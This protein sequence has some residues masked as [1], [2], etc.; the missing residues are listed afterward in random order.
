[1]SIQQIINGNLTQ[2]ICEAHITL[3]I[4]ESGSISGLESEQIREGLRNFIDSQVYTENKI[5]LIGMSDSDNNLRNDHLLNN[6]ITSSSITSYKSWINSFRLRTGN[7]IS[8]NSDYWAS[9]LQVVNSMQLPPDIVV[10]ITDGLQVQTPSVLKTLMATLNSSS[11]IFVYGINPGGDYHNGNDLKE[12]LTYYLGRNPILS[13]V[14]TDILTADYRNVLDFSALKEALGSLSQTLIDSNIG[15]GTLQLVKEDIDVGRISLDCINS[16]LNVGTITIKNNKGV[17]YLME[18][19]TEVAKINGLVFSS[20]ANV[21]LLPEG[22]EAK[23]PVQVNGTPLSIGYFTKNIEIEGIDNQYGLLVDFCVQDISL[24]KNSEVETVVGSQYQEYIGKLCQYK[25]TTSI[26]VKNQLYKELKLLASQMINNLKEKKSCS[27]TTSLQQVCWLTLENY[28]YNLTIPGQPAM[29][30]EQQ[31]MVNSAQRTV[32]PIWRPNTKFLVHFKLKDEVDNG[33]APAGIF[34]YYY[35]FKTAGPVGHYHKHPEI[36]YVPEGANPDQYP[37]TSLRQYID[38]NRSY[39]NA[40][41]NLLLAKPLFYGNKQCKITIYF[42][43]PLA[44]HMLNKWHAYNDLPELAGEMHIAI[45]DPVTDTIIPYP[46]PSN[47]S[48]ETVPVSQTFSTWFE[49]DSEDELKDL[50]NSVMLLDNNNQEAGVYEVLKWEYLFVSKKYHIR[51]KDDATVSENSSL[52]ISKIRV[53]NKKGITNDYLV[54]SKGKEDS[55]WNTDS[56]PRLPMQLQLL[57]NMIDYINANN[58][59]IKCEL[60]L[61]EPI[62][63]NSYAYNITLTNLKPQKLYTAL[64]YNAFDKNSSGTLQDTESEEVHQ[65]VFQT[66]RYSNF[67][68]QVKSYW[69]RELDSSG[70][71]LSERQAVFELPLNLTDDVV[72]SVYSIVDNNPNSLAKELEF[73]YY[74]LFDRAIEGVLGIKPIAPATNTEFNVIKNSNSN[75]IIGILIRNPEPFN[76]PKIPLKDIENTIA[77]VF[78]SSGEINDS[79]K[80]LYSKDYSQALIMHKS[81][82]ITAGKLNFRFQYKTWNAQ[83]ESYIVDVTDTNSTVITDAIIINS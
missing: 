11:H 9:G 36:S 27:Q 57:N 10:I 35:G 60:K 68:E 56:N 50:P 31:N 48:Q 32:Q 7:G 80:V 70:N 42:S 79:Y 71:T 66:S 19:G 51:I 34:D 59:A 37:L 74:H 40:D 29:E 82:E 39:P 75:K 15:C 61:G 81:K 47:F 58:T 28:E 65:F 2:G 38:Y 72:N 21:T 78:A 33:S 13:Y 3:V 46:L 6:Q 55:T 77:V 26:S 64:L 76:I 63:P 24:I 30:Q 22:Q 43:K 14:S 69:L 20:S 62:T 52:I 16:N 23:I 12:S 54:K 1:M 25:Q 17:P 83:N 4:D 44:Y 73:K 18:I 45:K 53:T 67:E 41:G 8:P 5:S 49:F